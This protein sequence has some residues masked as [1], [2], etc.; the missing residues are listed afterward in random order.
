MALIDCCVGVLHDR[1][2]VISRNDRST[3]LFRM[4]GA[5]DSAWKQPCNGINDIG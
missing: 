1:P 5:R 4:I 3:G 2:E